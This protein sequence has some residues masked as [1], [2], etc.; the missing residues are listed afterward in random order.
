LHF[1]INPPGA[2]SC[3][4]NAFTAGWFDY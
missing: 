2:G 1:K 4:K 3:G